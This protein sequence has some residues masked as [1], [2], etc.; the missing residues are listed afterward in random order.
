M[1]P[2]LLPL[3]AL[4]LPPPLLPVVLPRRKRRRKRKRRKTLEVPVVS[5]VVTM[6]GKLRLP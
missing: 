2:P 5:S 6:T 1:V 3:V 4:P